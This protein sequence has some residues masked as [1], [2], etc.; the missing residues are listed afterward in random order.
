MPPALKPLRELSVE[1]R[2]ESC[3]ELHCKPWVFSSCHS[4]S[5]HTG[6]FQMSLLLSEVEPLCS[7]GHW[8]ESCP[9]QLKMLCFKLQLLES[10]K[11]NKGEGGR[12]GINPNLK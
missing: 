8:K 6:L 5:G 1:V 7:S 4:K 10:L 12:I 3:E 2:R 11:Q 9:A